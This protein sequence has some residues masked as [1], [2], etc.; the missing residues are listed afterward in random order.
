MRSEAAMFVMRWASAL[1]ERA[2]YSSKRDGMASQVSQR[3]L[4]CA[5][6][7]TKDAV[8]ELLPGRVPAFV[9]AL[10]DGAEQGQ[11]RVGDPSQHRDHDRGSG[12]LQ[13]DGAFVLLEGDIQSL[14]RSLHTPVASDDEQP[15]LG[16]QTRARQTG[17]EVAFLGGDSTQGVLLLAD[18]PKDGA[19]PGRG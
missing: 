14:M 7:C 19:G 6:Q 9:G 12:I 13:D 11:Q 18:H 15:L 2:P 1:L 10:R 17:D 5:D 4:I 3:A 16:R 8:D